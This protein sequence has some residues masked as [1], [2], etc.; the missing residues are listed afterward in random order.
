MHAKLRMR[1]ELSVTQSQSSVQ[2]AA[3]ETAVWRPRRIVTF[4]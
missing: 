1:L 3:E 2:M 4:S